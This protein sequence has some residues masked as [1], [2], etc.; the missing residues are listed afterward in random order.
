MTRPDWIA[1]DWGTSNLRVWPMAGEVPLRRIDSDRGMGGLAS[2]DFEP[3]LIETLGDTLGDALPD[4]G[5]PLDV[6][7][8]GMAG[9]KQ[10]WTEA[11][12]VSVPCAPV[13]TGVPAPTSD[14]RLRVTILPGVSQMLPPDVMRGEETQIAGFLRN[15]P[16]FDG[17]VCMP[18]THT[19]WA[20]LSAGE[21]V[22]F[23]SFMTGEIFAL[24][25]QQSVLRHGM[26]DGWD[27]AAFAEGVSDAMGRPAGLASELFSLRAAGLLT[28]TSPDA[29]KSRLSGLLIGAE[30]SAAR[31]YWLGQNIV[32][33]GEGGM[34]SAYQTALSAQGAA[35]TTTST[36][37]ATLSGL[38]AAYQALRG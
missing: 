32:I 22:S 9:A 33:L 10:G 20:H 21:I 25:S 7:I 26:G 6:V 28:G 19:K 27:G 30:L 36:D 35:A 8:C 1:V 13:A 18:G 31:P 4:G 29:C 12:Y 3:T 2:A 5:A 38:I 34:A 37:D 24:L 16:E 15:S 17:I 14:P 23:R 11:P